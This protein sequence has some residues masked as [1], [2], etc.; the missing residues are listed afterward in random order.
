MLKMKKKIRISPISAV[1]FFVL[2]VYS[3]ALVSMVVWGFF[4][5]L[6]STH[7]FMYGD[8]FS[9]FPDGGVKNWCWYNYAIV[10][11]NFVIRGSNNLIYDMWALLGNSILYS[12]VCSFLAAFVPFIVSYVT[13]KY[14]FFY[15]NFINAMVIVLI[16]LPIVGG[17]APTIRLL[18]DLGWFDTVFAMIVM[19]MNFVNTYFL[20]YSASWR[21]IPNEYRDAAS[22][23]GASELAIFLQIMLPMMY[24]MYFTVVLIQ[25]VSLWNDY[26][27]PLIYM[28]SM[29]VLAYAVQNISLSS[30]PITLPTGLEDNISSSPYRLAA[31]MILL[32]PIL[33]LFIIFHDRLMGNLSM[34]GLKE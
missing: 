26:T 7:D 28:P 1:V 17:N 10:Y 16:S 9:L 21:G 20:I 27:W 34:G 13:S 12:V 18:Y 8:P 24:K 25:F 4:N 11:E 22:I 32:M 19:H 2:L 6:K 23:D 3:I 14:N 31:S 5:S 30:I 33:I 29:P 15:C